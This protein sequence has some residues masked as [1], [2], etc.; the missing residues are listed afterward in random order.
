MSQVLQ[1]PARRVT[2]FAASSFV[3]SGV[4]PKNFLP[5]TANKNTYPIAWTPYLQSLAAGQTEVA[6]TA[7]HV[8][9]NPP[10]WYGS[11]YAPVRL[12][13]IVLCDFTAFSGI[14][15]T[16]IF[17]PLASQLDSEKIMV[18]TTSTAY[19]HSYDTIFRSY[20]PHEAFQSVS[21]TF[22]I[23]TVSLSFPK[24]TPTNWKGGQVLYLS[25]LDS[26]QTTIS[27]TDAIYVPGSVSLP[28]N[29]GFSELV[30]QNAFSVGQIQQCRPRYEKFGYHAICA[31]K[32]RYPTLP[33]WAT[34]F[35][36]AATNTTPIVCTIVAHGRANGASVTITGGL[37]MS[38]INGTFIITVIDADNFSL[39]VSSGNGTYVQNS[40]RIVSAFRDQQR[41]MMAQVVGQAGQGTS[42]DIFDESWPTNQTAIETAFRNKVKSF[43]SLV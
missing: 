28:T 8:F 6:W 22:S 11:Q 7:A 3:Q 23:F 25:A 14:S 17:G 9:R 39:N 35:I 32:S 10:R 24:V 15:L 36:S 27:A 30:E 33:Q 38:S 21:H 18:A 19:L 43:F 1:L 41:A 12:P 20:L 29:I 42:I 2:G 40:A 34:D 16:N 13:R 37:G 4:S 31:L 5:R 26:F